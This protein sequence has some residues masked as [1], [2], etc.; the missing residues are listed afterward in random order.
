VAH[1]VLLSS[2]GW[3]LAVSERVVG[4]R[5]VAMVLRLWWER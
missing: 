3:C 5:G 2:A 4:L 1:V